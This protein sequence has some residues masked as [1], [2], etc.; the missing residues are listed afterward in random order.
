MSAVRKRAISEPME[1]ETTFSVVQIAIFAGES[2][3]VLGSTS[4]KGQIYESLHVLLLKKH[5]PS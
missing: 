2:S 5:Y 1:S 4:L 3:Y